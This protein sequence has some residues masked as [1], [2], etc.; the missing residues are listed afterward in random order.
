MPATPAATAVRRIHYVLSS[1]WDREW[2]QPFQDYRYR[3]VRLLDATLDRLDSGELAGAFQTDGQSIMLEDYLEVRRDERAR[4]E[5]LCREGRLEVGPWYVLPDEFIVSGESLVRN[6]REGREVARELDAEPSSAGFVCD[7]FGHTGQLPQVFAGFGIRGGFV[8]RGV[9]PQP[10]RHVV[11]VGSDGTRLPCYRFGAFGYCDFSYDV[12]RAQEP[13]ESLSAEQLREHVRRHL[14]QEEGLTRIDPILIFDGGDHQEWDRPAYEALRAETSTSGRELVHSSLDG[15]LQEMLPQAD[16]IEA[17][18][19]GE[20]REP[21]RAMP[22]EDGQALIPGVLSSRVWIKQDNAYCQSLLTQWAE[23]MG[24]LAQR[25]LDRPYPTDFLRVAWRWL[26]KNHPHDSICGCSIDQVHEDMKF[27]F[28]QCRQ[29]GERLTTE[30]TRAIAQAVEGEIGENELRVVVFNPL[31]RPL[32]EPFEIELEIP[33]EWPTFAE[34]FGY[35]NKPAFRLFDCDGKELAYQRLGQD[36]DRLQMKVF[37][38]KYTTLQK[39]HRVRVCLQTPLPAMGYVTLTARAGDK[40]VP[41]RHPDRPRMADS[42][43]SITNGLLRVSVEPNGSLTLQ[44]L[45]NNQTYERCLTFDDAA[46]IGDG[47]NH[48]PPVNDR[49]IAS[50]ACAAEVAI[51]YDTPLVAALEVT[52]KMPVNRRFDFDRRVRSP[53]RTELTLTS[54]ITLRQGC[55]RVEV[56]TQVDNTAEDHRLRVLFPTGADTEAMLSDAPFDAVERPIELRGD[57]HLYREL[58]VDARPQQ[59]WSAVHDKRRGLAVVAEGLQEA[60]ALDRPERPL[61]LTLFRSTRRTV[62]TDGEPEGLLL[63][64]M[65]FRYWLVPLAGEPDRRELFDLSAQLH[66]G[67]R[68]AQL[69][70]RDLAERDEAQAVAPATA[71]LLEV[72][73]QAVL[74]ATE[75]RAERTELRLFNPNDRAAEVTLRLGKLADQSV[76]PPTRVVPVDLE[77]NPTSDPLSIRRGE[78]SLTLEPKKITTLR[79]EP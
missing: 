36:P 63:G 10:T 7:L 5:R 11:W 1:H 72:Q 62:F 37:Y 2:Y 18:V 75:H 15:Y 59:S 27:R 48:G 38:I 34:F 67:L 29:I 66:A 61:A 56:E 13:D 31:P 71:S 57:N 12:R 53:E 52:V 44:D 3:L 41:T 73:G 32:D 45:E 19:H 35:E 60:A 6:L 39:L 46:D 43:R 20:L 14:D 22:P 51:I 68:T 4:V 21:G 74:T 26:L 30:M 42:E 50:T 47:W 8:W 78:L 16:L 17:Q 70:A 64:T 25:L 76:D 9:Q 40:T 23:P 49:T 58:E 65:R 54:R 79:L 33:D 55:R 28:S 24:V 77:S 69:R